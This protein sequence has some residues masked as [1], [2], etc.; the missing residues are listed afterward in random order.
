MLLSIIAVLKRP[1]IYSLYC[2]VALTF[3]PGTK[4]SRTDPLQ[5]I[6]IL[7]DQIKLR[8]PEGGA[9]PE[10]SVE[11][12]EPSQVNFFGIS[13]TAKLE[14]A[15]FSE[16]CAFLVVPDVLQQRTPPKQHK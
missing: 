13:P 4:T 11:A 7:R 16:V 5:R 9:L 12:S 14:L 1:S 3:R 6:L 10:N 15:T 8:I 2:R